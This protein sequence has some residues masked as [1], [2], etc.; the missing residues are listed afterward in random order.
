MDGGSFL[1]VVFG[2]RV[3]GGSNMKIV[4]RKHFL[5]HPR[6][7]FLDVGTKVGKKSVGRP[8]SQN[9]DGAHWYVSEKQCH[10]S[11]RTDGVGANG[12]GIVAEEIFGL[13]VACMSKK[14]IGRFLRYKF[15]SMVER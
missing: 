8:S 5:A 4:C 15:S 13:D 12:H 9:H 3:T 11:S 14:G 7:P 2:S 1:V 6:S 10:C